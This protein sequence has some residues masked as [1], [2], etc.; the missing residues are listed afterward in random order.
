MKSTTQDK[1]MIPSWFRKYACK[2]AAKMLSTSTLAL[3]CKSYLDAQAK[4]CYCPPTYGWKDPP[5]Q[6][7]K[8]KKKNKQP[9]PGDRDQTYCPN[10]HNN[11]HWQLQYIS[12]STIRLSSSCRCPHPSNI[13]LL[14]LTEES[15]ACGLKTKFD[16]KDSSYEMG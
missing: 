5:E 8:N 6:G 9:M 4:A 14:W 1:L 3:G 7:W 12:M 16:Y 11:Q 15:K 10:I 13:F 2:G